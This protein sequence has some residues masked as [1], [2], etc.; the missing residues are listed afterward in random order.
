MPMVMKE[1]V[2]MRYKVVTV[3]I[4][5]VV[6]LLVEPSTDIAKPK[7]SLHSYISYLQPLFTV[8]SRYRKGLYNICQFCWVS[9]LEL[10]LGVTTT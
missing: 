10:G 5:T 7:G 6:G 3:K 8:T 2:N 9:L 1:G 4:F